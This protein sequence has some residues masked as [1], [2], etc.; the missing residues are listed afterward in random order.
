MFDIVYPLSLYEK[1][2]REEINFYPIFV[3]RRTCTAIYI[4]EHD[5]LWSLRS[6]LV[7]HG[8]ILFRFSLGLCFF[9]AYITIRFGIDS[10]SD[11]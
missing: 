4:V 11:K 9:L 5:V 1:P 10:I 8:I 7:M 6:G 2:C 3:V